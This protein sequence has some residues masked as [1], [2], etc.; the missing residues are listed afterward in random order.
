MHYRAT[1][2]LI[3]LHA[4]MYSA[5]CPSAVFGQLPHRLESCL[6]YPTLAEE[7]QGMLRE[8]RSEAQRKLRVDD[9]TIN[10]A[11]DLQELI[12]EHIARWFGQ[13]NP[14]D[15]NFNDWIDASRE[16]VRDELRS[17]GYFLADVNAQVHVLRS[18]PAE[19][20]VSVAFQVIEGQQ[21]RLKEIQ[22][23]NEHLYPPSCLRHQFLL[24]DGDI[25]NLQKIREGITALTK[26]YG[27]Q[28]YVNF[29]VSPDFRIDNAHQQISALMELEEGRQFRVGSVEVLG[30]DRHL[31]GHARKLNLRP[32]DVFDPKLIEDFYHDN[33]S[34][35]PADFSPG[36]DI[37]IK[38]DAR[39]CTVAIVIDA[40]SCPQ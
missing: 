28:G 14:Y 26:L 8:E 12:R 24:D 2:R 17:H 32:G 22:F 21:Y 30:Y 37:Q 31:F 9:I 6:P 20:R 1:I 7:I 11:P 33:K 29:T 19:Q 18:D 35:L 13:S 36:D 15:D 23:A 16:T 40:R 25:M 10:G 34:A 27:H 38:Q 5:L 4:A 3:L 39:K